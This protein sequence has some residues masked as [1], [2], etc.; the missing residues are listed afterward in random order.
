M[1]S[2]AD[3]GCPAKAVGWS[4]AYPVVR[5]GTN[6]K[7]GVPGRAQNSLPGSPQRRYTLEDESISDGEGIFARKTRI[8]EICPG[9][10]SQ[11]LSL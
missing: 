1:K 4:Q 8:T 3:R 6:C 7:C 5:R 11:L 2:L 10:F 9:Q